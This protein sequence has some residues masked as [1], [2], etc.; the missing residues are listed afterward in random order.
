MSYAPSL[1]EIG[2]TDLAARFTADPFFADV[3]VFVLRPRGNESFVTI[4]SKI[5]QLIGGLVKKNG[6]SGAAVFV[7]MPTA[8]S[9]NPDTPGPR[10]KFKYTVRV[11]ELPII[12]M[13]DNGTQKSAEE[14]ALR[15]LQ[16]G[17]HFSPG[18]GNVIVAASDAMTPS[19]DAD[20]KITIDVNFEQQGGVRAES[21]VITPALTSA[22]AVDPDTGND[23]TITCAT[24]GASILYSVDG[25]YPTLPYTVPVNVPGS[26]TVRA[27]ATKSGLLPS[28]VRQI[29]LS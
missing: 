14:I 18:T 15:V 16:L 3:G 1:L 23:V 29:T 28:D 6:K 26:A 4:Q 12:N 2:Q 13:G 9:V 10:L 22:P 17:H 11:Q 25:T 21:K 20:P 5:D 27:V 24:A 8:D 19:A 7:L